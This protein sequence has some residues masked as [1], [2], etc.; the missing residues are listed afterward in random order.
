MTL[1]YIDEKTNEKIDLSFLILNCVQSIQHD[2]QS[3]IN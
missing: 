3:Y 1:F 2:H